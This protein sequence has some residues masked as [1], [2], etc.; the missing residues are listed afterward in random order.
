M[1]ATRTFASYLILYNISEPH[2]KTDAAGGSV[3]FFGIT[4][5]G[6]VIPAKAGIHSPTSG[7]SSAVSGHSREGGNPSRDV[8]LPHQPY[9]VIPA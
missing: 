1:R 2:V 4:T 6:A 3:Y 8:R 5:G 9:P 7:S